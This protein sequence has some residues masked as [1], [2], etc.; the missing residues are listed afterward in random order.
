[1]AM[2][3]PG[4]FFLLNK[5]SEALESLVTWVFPVMN[6]AWWSVTDDYVRFPGGE[7][8]EPFTED[9]SLHLTFMVLMLPAVVPSRS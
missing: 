5:C 2:D 8:L 1:M 9:D 7:Q 3:K 6:K 4:R